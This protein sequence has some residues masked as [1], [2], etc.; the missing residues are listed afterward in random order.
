MPG[1]FYVWMVLAVLAFATSFA[2]A[3]VSWSCPSEAFQV[4][5]GLF[6]RHSR[7]G[8]RSSAFSMNM[9]PRPTHHQQGTAASSSDSWATSPSCAAETTY[10][11]DRKVVHIATQQARSWLGEGEYWEDETTTISDIISQQAGVSIDRAIQ[12]VRFGAV[13]IGEVVH[14]NF[15]RPR[16]GVR[17]KQ[18]KKQQQYH[19]PADGPGGAR[20][21]PS[22]A[23]A[24][25]IA[26]KA[27]EQAPFQG[28][29]FEHM[30]LRRLDGTEALNFPPAGSYLRVHCDPRTFPV[31]DSTEWSERIVAVTEDYVIADKPA[32]VP[33][34]PTI[35]N[36]IENALYQTGVAIAN[37]GGDP[38]STSAP[39]PAPGDVIRLLPPLPTT[40]LHAV[41]RLDVCTSGLIVFARN[42]ASAT[43]LNQIF[44]DR[45][46]TK[47]YLAL[48]TPGPAVKV[49][50]A[51]HCCRSKAFDGQ[52]RPRVY[53]D[54][55]EELL[56]GGKWGGAWQEARCTV[57]LCAPVTKSAT[58]AAAVAHDR[59]ET[60]ATAR[61]LDATA[62]GAAAK[63][64]TELAAGMDKWASEA[65]A[66]TEEAVPF[67]QGIEDGA[68]PDLDSGGMASSVDGVDSEG[69]ST[70]ASSAVLTPEGTAEAKEDD[71]VYPAHLCAMQLET[72]RTHQLRLQLA[73]MGAA[74][75]GDTRYRG[76]VGRVHRG[77]TVDDRT[78]RFG[79]EPEA[80]YLQAARLQFEWRGTQVSYSADRPPWAVQDT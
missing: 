67:G 74:V 2:A 37:L 38:A 68:D 19:Q 71:Q 29:S 45:E 11:G 53:A 36:A 60:E 66:I 31:V 64:E 43:T 58:A 73:A 80:I 70:P 17:G 41:S 69:A 27:A 44:R 22:V 35:D 28:T 20:E 26:A 14:N 42:K 57:L 56:T 65:A 16:K 59:A 32:G 54:F 79:Q 62:A 9:T 49:G 48:L 63:L 76:V 40:P 78:D 39:S 61:D 72:G 34:V 33:S 47:R 46:V 3:A 23:A 75:V 52:R 12:L 51:T 30:R 5:S 25:K 4:Q 18:H 8:R 21:E 10:V 13:Y 7:P 77:L 6:V 15:N 1:V 55:D 24:V 50:S